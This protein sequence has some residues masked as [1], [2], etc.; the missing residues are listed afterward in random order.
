[1]KAIRYILAAAALT[2]FASCQKD[3]FGCFSS[4][5]D[6]VQITATVGDLAQTRVNPV[7]STEEDRT[8]FAEGE[9]INVSADS[10]DAVTYKLESGV[11][12]PDQDTYLKWNTASMTF[13]AYYPVDKYNGT[14][15]TVHATQN[16]LAEIK[17]ADYMKAENIVWD[18]S[19]GSVEFV[20]QRQTARVVIS[21]IK[22]GNQYGSDMRICPDGL[23]LSDGVSGDI[24]PYMDNGTYYALLMP[25]NEKVDETFIKITVWDGEN[26]A[27]KETLIV[28][29]IPALE[30]GYSYECTLTIGK[31][32]V[33]ISSVTVEDWATGGILIDGEGL[34]E[35]F[36]ESRT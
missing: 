30:A 13:N 26:D 35:E 8:T 36:F 23:T 20:M 22:W 24:V 12:K 25:G 18:K 17:L 33:E 15:T 29:D 34:T 16:N 9:K 4:D 19:N 32:K 14:Q 7:G 5:P 28:K 3:D 27:S 6:A 2:C 11:W 21:E 10:Q 31:D 1:M